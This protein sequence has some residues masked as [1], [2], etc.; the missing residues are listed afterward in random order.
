MKL[1]SVRTHCPD[2]FDD[3]SYK[4]AKIHVGYISND[5]HLKAHAQ[6]LT[7]KC[8]QPKAHNQKPT[9]KSPFI[10]GLLAAWAYGRWFLV[11]VGF[12]RWAFRF[13]ELLA[14]G[15]WPWAFFRG[16]IFGGEF[17]GFALLRNEVLQTAEFLIAIHLMCF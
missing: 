13:G 5:L 9:V 2:L 1:N 4:D 12:C 15:L 14:V 7:D 6:M 10:G 16:H 8:S 17:Q 11:L 3:W